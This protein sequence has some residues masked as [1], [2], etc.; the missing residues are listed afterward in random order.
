MQVKLQHLLF[1]AFKNK[2]QSLCS[3]RKGLPFRKQSS[4]LSMT[5]VS[6][7]MEKVPVENPW[8]HLTYIL[9][10]NPTQFVEAGCNEAQKYNEL[11]FE[12]KLS[13]FH[14]CDLASDSQSTCREGE[15][16]SH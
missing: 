14:F 10:A 3:L 12:C 1:V 2:A 15:Y 4:I 9:C 6:S 16:L 13:P 7:A 11:G 5:T 8:V